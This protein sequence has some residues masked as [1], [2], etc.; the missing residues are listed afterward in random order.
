MLE[1]ASASLYL[2]VA[3][4]KLVRGVSRPRTWGTAQRSSPR[5]AV[6]RIKGLE[7]ILVAACNSTCDKSIP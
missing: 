2:G 3:L 4:C 7:M 5:N 6:V 1:Q